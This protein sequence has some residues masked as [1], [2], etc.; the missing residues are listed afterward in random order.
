MRLVNGIACPLV[1]ADL[2]EQL[3]WNHKLEREG[4]FA[5]S[6]EHSWCWIVI[7]LDRLAKFQKHVLGTGSTRAGGSFNC[8]S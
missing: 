8:G 2:G 5:A 6:L 3:I 7:V 1:S 4:I